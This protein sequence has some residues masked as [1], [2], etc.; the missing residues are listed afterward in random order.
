MNWAPWSPRAAASSQMQGFSLALFGG[1]RRRRAPPLPPKRIISCKFRLLEPGGPQPPC[2]SPIVPNGLGSLEPAGRNV[3]F[4]WQK[5]PKTK[6]TVKIAGVSL[7]TAE[8][9]R[10]S[11][12]R[13]GRSRCARRSF[14]NFNSAFLLTLRGGVSV[15]AKANDWAPLEPAGRSSRCGGPQLLNVACAL[16]RLRPEPGQHSV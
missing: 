10:F 15:S 4:D 5:V 3:L 16:R 1:T 2:K 7:T 8:R 13:S 6:C 11:H 9:I 12:I 14:R